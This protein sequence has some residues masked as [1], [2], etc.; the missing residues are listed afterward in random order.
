MPTAGLLLKVTCEVHN[1]HVFV[2]G[3]NTGSFG[4]TGMDNLT[5]YICHSI[6]SQETVRVLICK[7]IVLDKF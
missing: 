6:S 4:C 5:C 1:L 2:N 7:K 3:D